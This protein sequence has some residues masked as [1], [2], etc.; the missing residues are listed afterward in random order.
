MYIPHPEITHHLTA[1]YAANLITATSL[2]TL[3]TFVKPEWLQEV[4]RLGKNEQATG[5][6]LEDH[7]IL[8]PESK[9]RPGYS[10]SLPQEQKKFGLWEPNEERV[11]LFHPCRFIC[12]QEK[13]TDLDSDIRETI[14]RGRGTL[15]T[16]DIHSGIPKFHRAIT[17]S[18]AKEGKKTVVVGDADLMQ[19]AVGEDTYAQ[20]VTESKRWAL[21]FFCLVWFYSIQMLIVSQSF[22]LEILPPSTL[23]QAALNAN[24]ESLFPS[25]AMDVDSE[26]NQRKVLLC[27]YPISVSETLC[28]S[29]TL[30]ITRCCTQFNP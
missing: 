29:Y 17:R 13:P 23:V 18:Q 5:V 4:I 8:P 26:V 9:F 7:F 30:T 19:T 25:I 16:F 1:Q 28:S 20:F 14:H 3:S 12:L 21:F 15:E 11:N 22:G 10:P 6:C 27:W 24:V 2:L